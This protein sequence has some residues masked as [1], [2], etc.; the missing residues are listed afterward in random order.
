M[1]LL[2]G[3]AGQ[4]WDLWGRQGAEKTQRCCRWDLRG[5]E[6]PALGSMGSMGGYGLAEAP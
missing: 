5:R 2:M 4:I 6:D 3:S 1:P